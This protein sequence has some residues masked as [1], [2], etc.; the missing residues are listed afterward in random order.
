MKSYFYKL[1]GAELSRFSKYY[2]RVWL[3]RAIEIRDSFLH[4]H[5]NN[6]N[7]ETLSNNKELPQK[8]ENDLIILEGVINYDNNIQKTL[9]DL[10]QKINRHGRI[11]LVL[12]NS[13]FKIF[14]QIANF[15][16]LRKNPIPSVFLT[17]VN[18]E[19]LAKLSGYELIYL[20]PCI[21]I[22]FYIPIISS[23]LN[24][25]L[26]TIGFLKNFS[27]VQ[28]AILR[29]IKKE[30]SFPGLS[31]IIPARNERG[32][33]QNAITKLNNLPTNDIEIIFVE[34]NSTD[35]T[36]EEIQNLISNYKGDF[37]LKLFKQKSK[38]KKDAVEVGFNESSK[39]L[40]TILDADL[41]MPPEFLLQFYKA[42]CD[43]HGD[44]INGNRLFY[45]M[46]SEAMR[47]LNFLGNIFFA[48]SL[49][50]VLREDL[51]DSLC[52]TKLFSKHHLKMIQKWNKDFGNFDPFG[53]FEMLFPASILGFGII[54][55]P[56]PYRN[57]EYGVTNI[58]R[59]NHGFMLLKM[60]F[61]GFINVRLGKI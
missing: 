54:N 57:R 40:V 50:Y 10:Q 7:I 55:I 51:S 30:T 15:L 13:Y 42:Y 1:I 37:S 11:A 12:F 20:R 46:E 35:G 22:P 56:I 31:I 39:D 41:T 17:K 60:T 61:I 33:I 32:N 21:F 24:S 38:G 28:I 4:L 58:Q 29:P 18:L 45:P 8:L 43:G 16:K 52:G 2:P 34:G 47:P 59:F 6:D 5:L 25:L 53:D 27:F 48:K 23:I 36:Y 26:P 19:N 44:F 49:S 9:E 14:Y 3:V